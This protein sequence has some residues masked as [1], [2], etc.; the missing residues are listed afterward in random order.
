MPRT[1]S[2]AGALAALA[3]FAF[4]SGAAA[5]RAGS[6]LV[7]ID[8]SGGFSL[9]ETPLTFTVADV[10]SGSLRAGVPLRYGI[11]PWVGGALAR[12]RN[13]GCDPA[14]T[15]CSDTERRVLVGAMYMPGAPGARGMGP[16]VGLGLGVRSF[17][18]SNDLAH[19]VVLGLP[20]AGGSALAPAIELRSE[21]YR[22][23][24]NE[25]LIVAVGIRLGVRG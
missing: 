19:S 9:R 11:E 23:F 16:Y 25:L 5:Q 22:G 1:F 15:N 4:A 2:L 24:N 7:L 3:L 12:L 13:V 18:G 14:A 6:P 20:L 21:S 8:G 10:W 17:R